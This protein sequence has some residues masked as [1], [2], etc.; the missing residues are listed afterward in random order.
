VCGDPGEARRYR[1]VRILHRTVWAFAFCESAA[2]ECALVRRRVHSWLVRLRVRTDTPR[3]LTAIG[4]IASHMS[5]KRLVRAAR[6][7]RRVKPAAEVPLGEFL[8]SNGSVCCRIGRYASDDRWC[9]W[10]GTEDQYGASV[11]P[12]GSVRLCG[13]G[14]PVPYDLCTQNWN[15][16]AIHLEDGRSSDFGGFTC[17]DHGGAVTCTV[18]DGRGFVVGSTGAS[19]VGPP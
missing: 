18:E 13:T 4:M 17:I 16:S 6:S 5:F 14:Q 9:V 8:S 15:S 3:R 2:P 19:A 1:K 11:A 12:D 7:L 10:S